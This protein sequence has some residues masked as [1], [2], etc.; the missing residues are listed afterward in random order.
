[1]I[2]RLKLEIQKFAETEA[3]YHSY[4]GTKLSYSATEEGP[5]TQ[6]KGITTTPDIGS[7]PEDIE[8][9]TMDNQKFKTAISGLQDV[10]K[11]TF[12]FNMEDPNV[13]ANF[14]LA[15]DLEDAGTIAYWKYELSNGVT[16]SFRSDVKTMIRGGSYGDLIGFN[17]TLTPI[18][19]IKKDL[20][21]SASV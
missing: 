20:G 6:I 7:E 5:Y 9:T 8:T 3:N 13:E 21:I 12:E 18:G 15:S 1:M 16:I 19:E 2:L 10:Q 14:K 11:Y 4:T 17:M